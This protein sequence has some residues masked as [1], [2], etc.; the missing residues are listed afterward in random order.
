MEDNQNNE[1]ETNKKAL[2]VLFLAVFID[3]MGFGIIIPILPF[4]VKNV[5]KS[6][7]FTYGLL[8][9][10]FSV[11]QFIFAPI[12]GRL[13]D[14]RGRRPIILSG[15]TIS[16]I[17]FGILTITAIFYIESL[18]MVFLSRI[19]SGIGT[20]ATL[21]TSQAYIS[22]TT[23]GED[24]AKGF[25]LL[26]AAFGLGF[27]FGPA[28]GSLFTILAEII[29][30]SIDK[31]YWGP[32][33]FST[34]LA[35]VNLLAAINNIPETHTPKKSQIITTI[36][37]PNETESTLVILRRTGMFSTILI[38]FITFAIVSLAFSG[39]EVTIALFGEARFGL[40]EITTG[41]VLLVVGIVAI[42]TQGGFIRPLSNRFAP[43]YLI[44]LGLFFLLLSFLGLTTV[45]DLPSMILW[46]IPLAFGSSVAQPTIG[47]QLSKSVPKEI[48]GTI[49]GLNQGIG[50]LTRIFGPLLG[51]F[52]LEINVT[53]PYY[54]GSLLLLIAFLLT[55]LLIQ[56]VN[57]SG[58]LSTCVNCSFLISA[59]TANCGEC[60]ATQRLS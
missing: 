54:F 20:A 53:Y 43:S 19:V 21:P 60:G 4:W 49:L 1:Q 7:E 56:K 16:I 11:F 48:Q 47:S 28:L 17:G 3:I 35:L 13:S 14:R 15:L 38:L 27:A 25:G 58:M 40:D 51:T 23:T 52:L 57:D 9:S 8:I 44:A 6:S 31:G 59:N 22:D 50:S 24:R 29:V 12:W 2:F 46:I 32:A 39:M 34:I 41:L 36:I 45:F 5:I 33:L 37:K 55:L 10:S 26:G 30:P 18:F 42:I